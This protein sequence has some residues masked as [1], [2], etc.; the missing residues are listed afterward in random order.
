MS[1]GDDHPMWRLCLVFHSSYDL[2]FVANVI[3]MWVTMLGLGL[4]ASV[5]DL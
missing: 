3:S 5:D 2:G 4:D 1:G